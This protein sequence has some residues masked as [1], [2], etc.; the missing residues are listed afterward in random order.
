MNV[1]IYPGCLSFGEHITF[2]KPP[3]CLDTVQLLLIEEDSSE[4]FS[5]ILML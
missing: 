2:C 5:Y 3:T 1:T 4:Q